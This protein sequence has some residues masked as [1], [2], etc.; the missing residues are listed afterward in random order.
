MSYV[1]SNVV[2]SKEDDYF[3]VVVYPSVLILVFMHLPAIMRIITVLPTVKYEHYDFMFFG[4][5]VY[6][7]LLITT[8]V[9]KFM[10]HLI[11][12]LMI[13]K[14]AMRRARTEP[15][16]P[17]WWSGVF[18]AIIMICWCLS[19]INDG[20]DVYLDYQVYQQ[21]AA[22]FPAFDPPWFK[23]GHDVN[24]WVTQQYAVPLLS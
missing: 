15:A 18:S 5:C 4:I 22:P 1:Y 23:R 13:A 19:D 11:H 14:T 21:A 6:I 8:Q 16:D 10:F 3:V 20:F 7:V 24:S 2:G 17:V 12:V 9:K